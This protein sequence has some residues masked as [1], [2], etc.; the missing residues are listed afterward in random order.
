MHDD[1]DPVEQFERALDAS[2]EQQEETHNEE[3]ADTDGVDDRWYV[4]RPG[5]PLGEKE[6]NRAGG[7][8]RPGRPT[9]L[10]EIEDGVEPGPE[11][12][13]GP[14]AHEAGE[15]RLTR[16]HRVTH[17]LGVEDGLEQDR[18]ARDPKEREPVPH[19][20]GGSEEELAAPI[21]APSTCTPG[22]TTPSQARPLGAAAWQL[23]AHHGS[24]PERLRSNG[25][26]ARVVWWR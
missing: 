9:D 4:R 23:G 12:G 24:R 14:C 13:R 18:D 22:P 26:T 3:Q 6:K 1:Q 21:E 25:E 10:Q 16:R 20:G 8:R 15:H 2:T 5:Q 19:E 11:R 17:Q 7:V